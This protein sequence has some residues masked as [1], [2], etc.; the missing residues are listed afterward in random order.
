MRSK[1]RIWFHC[2][3]FIQLLYLVVRPSLIS[4]MLTPTVIHI[5]HNFSYHI[6]LKADQ[7]STS[8][9]YIRMKTRQWIANV[10]TSMINIEQYTLISRKLDNE[11]QISKYQSYREMIN[12]EQLR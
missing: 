5:I 12:I 2:P 4:P 6:R 8:L 9:C 10:Q 11:S 3:V 1:R 7:T